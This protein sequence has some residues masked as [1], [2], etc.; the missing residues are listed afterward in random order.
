MK[1]DGPWIAVSRGLVLLTAELSAL[2]RECAEMNNS[3]LWTSRGTFGNC[4]GKRKKREE[5][6]V[7]K[8][9]QRVENT[10]AK[11]LMILSFH[12]VACAV[13]LLKQSRVITHIGEGSTWRQVKG[14]SPSK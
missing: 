9:D 4:L 10:N 14:L 3:E 5:A 11:W 1:I 2:L 13:F 12:C 8:E 7:W 6:T